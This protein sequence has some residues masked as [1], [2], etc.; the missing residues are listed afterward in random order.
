MS[1]DIEQFLREHLDHDEQ[2]IRRRWNRDGVT[3]EKFHG[4][5]FDPARA[6]AEVEAKRQMLA[7]VTSE[8]HYW[9]EDNWYACA[10]HIDCADE[11][12]AGKPCDCGRDERVRRRIH[13]L[14]LPYSDH[15]DYR[16]EW[17]P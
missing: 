6:I 4:T 16:K 11:D 17:R 1:G 13:L 7:D 2:E 12:R 8:G 14:A 3:S 5:P 15:P 10:A 9:C